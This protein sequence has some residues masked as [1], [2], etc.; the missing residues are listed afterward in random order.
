[1]EGKNTS[2]MRSKHKQNTAS[3]LPVKSKLVETSEPSLAVLFDEMQAI[4]SN[5]NTIASEIK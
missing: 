5:T 3:P 2:I 4:Y 1:M